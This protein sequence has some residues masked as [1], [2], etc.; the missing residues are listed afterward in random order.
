MKQNNIVSDTVYGHIPY[1]KLE[2]RFLKSKVV[3]RLLFVSQNA[4]AY[5]A[6]P[7]ISTK[8]YI[9]SL[10]TM[11]V[12]SYMFKNSL[13]NSSKKSRKS[14]LMSAK[15][16]I[17]NLIER[18]A[19]KIDLKTLDIYDK[20]LL[21]FSF[22]L[23]KKFNVSY[24]ILLQSLRLAGLLHDVGHL[25][26]SHQTEY[27]LKRLYLSIKKKKVLNEEEKKF[28]KFYNN[29]TT[30]GQLVLH[31]SIG[32]SY[33]DMLFRHELAQNNGTNKEIVELYYLMVKNILNNMET[34][35]FSYSTLHDY[36]AS[37]IDADRIDYIN[38][39]LLASGYISTSADFLRVTREAILIEENKKFQLSFMSSS[40][41]DI[42]H[43]LESRFNLYKKVF[44]THNIA[45]LD[46]LLEKVITYLAKEYLLSM[47]K[48]KKI[49]QSIAMMW[50]FSKEKNT[51]K[52]LDIISQLDENWLISLFKKEYFKIKYQLSLT[53][54][55]RYYLAAFEDILF[56]KHFFRAQW[57]NLSEFYKLL[58]LSEKE[59]YMF[60]EKFGKVSE[61]KEKRLEKLLNNFIHQYNQGDDFFSYSIISLSIGIDKNF[62]LYDGEKSIKIDEVSTLRK[63]LIT[64]RSNTVPFYIFTNKKSLTK[65]MK[66]ALR[67]IL[68]KVFL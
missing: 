22:I 56:G 28:L 44:F 6:F 13:I 16:E 38:R 33:L 29:I 52:Q 65:E 47:P 61:K 34:K 42:E 57:Q 15:V 20:T 24:L 60:R 31:E 40:L 7:S 4:L 63:R 30:N 19:L 14:F 55:E 3:N 12:A 45:R 67:E 32:Y 43:L 35:D 54:E 26:F 46:T 25:P 11:H 5:F 49:Y 39:D 27:A 51:V 37:S 68:F 21:G 50:Q 9:H 59:R 2:E 62:L 41:P 36:V 23:D 53:Y 17:E 48:D 64:S 66:E 58:E 8:R 18:H 10:G 1:S